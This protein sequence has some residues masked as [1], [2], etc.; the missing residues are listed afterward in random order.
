MSYLA[1]Q[2]SGSIILIGGLTIDGLFAKT[3]PP[4]CASVLTLYAI[5]ANF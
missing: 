3:F 2:F 1:V 5:L 4:I